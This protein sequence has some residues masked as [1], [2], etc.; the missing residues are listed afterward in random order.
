MR[1]IGENLNATEKAFDHHDLCLRHYNG[2][3]IGLKEWK[4]KSCHLVTQTFISS[5]MY[6]TYQ[7]YIRLPRRKKGAREISN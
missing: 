3:W 6:G 1:I 2:P 4:M 5:V 7:T